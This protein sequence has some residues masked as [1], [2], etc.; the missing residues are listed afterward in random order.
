MA[1]TR[2]DDSDLDAA[3]LAHIQAGSRTFK[4][5]CDALEGMDTSYIVIDRRL[6]NCASR[7]K[8]LIGRM[9]GWCGHEATKAERR[10]LDCRA[11]PRN[12][13]SGWRYH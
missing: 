10:S 9:G 8:S 13:D 7:I 1:R 4:A 6:R 12:G 5:L 11:M 3:I 2:K